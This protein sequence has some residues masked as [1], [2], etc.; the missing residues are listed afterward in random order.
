[1]PFESI[2]CH[3]LGIVIQV[4]VISY[5]RQAAA[6]ASI[7]AERARAPPFRASGPTTAASTRAVARALP[8]GQTIG[9][10]ER[11]ELSYGGTWGH[12]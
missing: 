1:M 4:P 11:H 2:L 6:G 12:L 7:G 8:A 9:A 10:C 3:S 5:Q